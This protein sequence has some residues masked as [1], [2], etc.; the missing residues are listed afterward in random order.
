MKTKRFKRWLGL[1]AAILLLHL[2]WWGGS[3]LLQKTLLPSPLT[4]YRAFPA[5][6]EKKLAGH[7]LASSRRI[8]LGMGSALIAGSGLGI[9]MGRSPRWNQVLDPLVYLV[10]PIPKLALLPILMLLFGLGETS[11]IILI[12]L[13]VF[14]QVV[15]GV[16][17][18][19]RRIP[20]SFYDIYGRLQASRWQQF[21]AITL[22]ASLAA[23]L[24]ASRV[25]L[26]T[27]ISVLFFTENYG[28]KFGM[29]YFIMD[30]WMRMDYP[31]MYGG[32]LL[33]SAF[34]LVLF[35]LIDTLAARALPWEQKLSAND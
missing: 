30:A 20:A 28:T 23:V 12:I 31:A 22:P 1:L 7:L 11:K 16:R 17:D 21:K 35:L 6:W 9:L 8:V 34:G 10:Y 29:G 18:A 24:S 33:L 4:V 13:I 27:A 14:P 5:L 2:L 32:I 15:L 25:S 19:V 26:G 3:L